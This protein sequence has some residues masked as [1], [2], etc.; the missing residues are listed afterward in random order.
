MT[1]PE[2][3]EPDPLMVDAVLSMPKA[4]RK[5]TELSGPDRCWLVAGLTNAGMTADEIAERTS[6][7]RRLVMAIRAEDMTQVCRIAQQQ[8]G[9]LDAELSAERSGHSVTRRDLREKIA[10]AGR[11]RVQ[12]DQ[13]VDAHLAG[14]L[15]LFQCGH[16]KVDWNV[17]QYVD[18]SGPAPRDREMCREC[19]NGRASR[20]RSRR[21]TAAQQ[22]NHTIGVTKM[23]PQL[24][25]STA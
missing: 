16:P 9:E 8:V 4:S 21:K 23:H 25:A 5:M 6:C 17:Y 10:E 19:A 12:L 1:S 11:L 24:V 18:R 13:I 14:T 15:T 7:S 3:W 2:R 20:Y 22:A